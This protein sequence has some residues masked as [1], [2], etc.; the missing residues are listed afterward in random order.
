MNFNKKKEKKQK[1]KNVYISLWEID[2]EEELC[3]VEINERN[4]VSAVKVIL[5]CV[6]HSRQIVFIQT[7]MLDT[8]I[9][10][11]LVRAFILDARS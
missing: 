3:E 1:T 10:F 7:I 8:N 4:W 6:S 2:L 11:E 5:H 9:C